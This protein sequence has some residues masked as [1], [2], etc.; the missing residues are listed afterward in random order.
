MSSSHPQQAKPTI[1]CET[2]HHVRGPMKE[3]WRFSV[4]YTISFLTRM[5]LKQTLHHLGSRQRSEL[6]MMM[7]KSGGQSN[8]LHRMP[9]YN[10]VEV[11]PLTLGLFAGVL[12]C[13]RVPV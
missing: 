6:P 2:F 1:Q 4:S 10:L 7:A 3:C 13:A 8:I 11:P 5:R 12:G 9:V